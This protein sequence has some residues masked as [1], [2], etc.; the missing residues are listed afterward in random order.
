MHRVV[1]ASFLI[2]L[3][4][5]GNSPA[6]VNNNPVPQGGP[7][8]VQAVSS[9]CDTGGSGPQC[10]STLSFSITTKAGN[11]ILVP[12]WFNALNIAVQVSDSNQDTFALWATVPTA[13]TNDAPAFLYAAQNAVGGAVTISLTFSC[14]Q[15]PCNPQDGVPASVFAGALEYQGITKGMDASVTAGSL[16][17]QQSQGQVID[18]GTFT[19]HLGNELVF[20]IAMADF[21]VDLGTG[22]T[23]RLGCDPSQSAT[24]GSGA[25]YFCFEEQTAMQAGSF[26]ATFATDFSSSGGLGAPPSESAPNGYGISAISVY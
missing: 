5:C 11:S 21:G 2:F 18:S 26:N 20:G 1:L 19:T 12:L 13:D 16:L 25:G 15:T 6:P 9:R 7:S 23:A 4:G 8:F 14:A 17:T 10:S 24:V 3:A 22:W